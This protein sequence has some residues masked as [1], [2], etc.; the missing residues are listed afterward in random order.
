V[1][2]NVFVYKKYSNDILKWFQIHDILTS[3]VDKYSW[4]I[5]IISLYIY[6][7]CKYIFSLQ[8]TSVLTIFRVTQHFV[9]FVGTFE[10]NDSYKRKTFSNI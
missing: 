1:S 9:S 6:I 8:S 2:T 7:K 3:W 5:R 4:K 10:S